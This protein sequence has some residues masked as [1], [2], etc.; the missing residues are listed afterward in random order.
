MSNSIQLDFEKPILELQQKMK[1][2]QDFSDEQN[3]DVNSEI[4]NMEQKIFDLKR[5]TVI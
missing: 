2:L 1:E 3:I 4:K 5:Y